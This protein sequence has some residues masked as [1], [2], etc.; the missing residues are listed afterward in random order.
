VKFVVHFLRLNPKT[1]TTR[2]QI[3]KKNPTKSVNMYGNVC[4][5]DVI[6]EEKVNIKRT[7][8][9]YVESFKED[10]YSMILK[11]NKAEENILATL[12]KDVSFH[13]MEFFEGKNLTLDEIL[14]KVEVTFDHD[15][16]LF[17]KNGVLY[18]L[19]QIQRLLFSFTSEELKLFLQFA[20]GSEMYDTS[21]Q[22]IKFDFSRS[23]VLWQSHTCFNQIEVSK[24]FMN[25]VKRGGDKPPQHFLDTLNSNKPRKKFV[26]QNARQIFQKMQTF[27]SKSEIDFQVLKEEFVEYIRM[28]L[29]T[30]V[31]DG[32]SCP[33]QM[34]KDRQ[35][36]P[37]PAPAEETDMISSELYDAYR[38]SG[39]AP[40]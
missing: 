14:L 28:A 18:A 22:N 38:Y 23:Y 26:R 7:S 30:E 15:D 3:Q 6:I 40:A 12:I 25:F 10:D 24:K 27:Y 4:V 5:I 8:V 21:Q 32:K 9:N 39:I 13:V 31:D 1:F 11:L 36:A 19:V 33:I 29:L 34:G 17:K 2:C 37:A 35:S 16:D 20:T